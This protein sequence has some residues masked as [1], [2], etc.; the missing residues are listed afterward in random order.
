MAGQHSHGD[1]LQSV[2]PV[3][4]TI[5]SSSDLCGLQAHMRYTDTQT[6]ETVTLSLKKK[7]KEKKRWLV[8]EEQRAR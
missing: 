2:A 8:G 3:P 7:Y 4:E 6:R 1:S 5:K